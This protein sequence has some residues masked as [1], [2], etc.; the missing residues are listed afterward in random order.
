M[1]FYLDGVN[2]HTVR[3]DQVD[4]ATWSSATDHGFFVILNVAMAGQFP[5]AFGCGPDADTEPG[6]P[7]TVDYVAV[8]QS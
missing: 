6:H 3:A 5:A 1:R 7:L 8:Y 4:A 2:F